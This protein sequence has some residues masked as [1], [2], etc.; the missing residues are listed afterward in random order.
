MLLSRGYSYNDLVKQGL[1][2]EGAAL[3]LSQARDLAEENAYELI[4][5]ISGKQPGDDLLLVKCHVC[6]KQT[7][8]R[9]GDVVYGCACKG[10]GPSIS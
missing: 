7:V 2:D 4:D 9:P 8:E 3:R 10:K 1:M 5:L 6:G